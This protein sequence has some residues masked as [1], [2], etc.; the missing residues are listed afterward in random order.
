[1]FDNSNDPVEMQEK[2]KCCNKCLKE[3]VF[4]AEKKR[5]KEIKSTE[6]SFVFIGNRAEAWKMWG[7]CV[8]SES[9]WKF[10]LLLMSIF[11]EKRK[12]GQLRVRIGEK[13]LEL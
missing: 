5:K 7:R 9:L 12:Q 2:D 11:L 1:M 6:S 8:I 10:S 13:M 3:R 4:W